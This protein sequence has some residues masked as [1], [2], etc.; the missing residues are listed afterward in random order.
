MTD[1][2][3][4]KQAGLSRREFFAVAAVAAPGLAACGGTPKAGEIAAPVEMAEQVEMAGPVVPRPPVTDYALESSDWPSFLGPA[5]NGISRETGLL[6]EWPAGGPPVI[7]SRSVGVSYSAPVIARGKLVFFHRQDGQ[8]I[9]ECVDPEDGSQTHWRHAYKTNYRDRYRYNGGPR[10]TPTI[11]GNRVYTYGA[12]G[13]ATCLD[14]ETGDLVWQ[15]QVN[16]EFGV[17]QGFFGVATSPV[18]EG[19]L[20]LLNV[21]GPGGAGVVAF[22]K[23]TG[24]TVWKASDQKASYSTPI[25]ATVHGERL[26]IFYT[27][28]GLLVLEPE[29]GAERFRYPFR[30]RARSSALA[31]TPVLVG[32]VVFL[33]ATYRVGAVALKLEPSG[34]VEVWKDENAM[35]NHWATSIYHEGYLYGMDG[36][37]E[38]GSNFRC[39]EFM[40]GKVM[41]SADE[42]LGRASFIMADGHFITMGEIGDLALIEVSPERYIEKARVRV[43]KSPAWIPPVLSHGLLYVRNEHVLAC[44]DLRQI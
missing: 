42:G 11:H 37:H 20:L 1:S 30:S 24:E 10:S 35:Q 34:L 44:R 14:F 22:N 6:K 19:N 3:K 26:A 13:M 4:M 18:I 31:A 23:E 33:S 43:L 15:R 40:T 16:K 38:R 17:R 8:E 36:R 2:G 9:I 27:A 28:G 41:W 12:E 5:H 39:I 7:W 32:D 21:G 29:T 25:V